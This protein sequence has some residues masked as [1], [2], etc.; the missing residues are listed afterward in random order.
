[1]PGAPLN[2]LVPPHVPSWPLGRDALKVRDGLLDD[3]AAG[4]TLA[5]LVRAVDTE[6]D[7]Q[8]EFCLTGFG[9]DAGPE[10][11]HVEPGGATVAL[12]NRWVSVR[13]GQ[14]RPDDGGTLCTL[15]TGPAGKWV[16]LVIRIGYT[17]DT[18][19]EADV[20]RLAT[21]VDTAEADE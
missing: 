10:G 9:S 4:V 18:P 19:T 2:R 8:H 21:A 7:V 14:C 3:G 5:R 1:M 11:W 17:R 12:G 20:S 6:L 15:L 16:A 13:G